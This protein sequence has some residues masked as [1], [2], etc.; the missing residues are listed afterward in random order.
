MRE[1]PAEL[2]ELQRLLDDSH[3]RAGEHLTGII[4]ADRTLRASEICGLMTGMRVLA[5]ATVT[6]HGEPRI[7][8]VDGHFLHGR[9]VFTTSGTAA[10]TRHLRARPATSVAHIDGEDVAVYCHGRAEP[11]TPDHPD[12]AGVEE[13]LVAHYGSSPTSWGPDIAYFRV[14][15]SW[16]V[17]YAWRRSELLARAEVAEEPRP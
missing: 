2:A 6:A 8:G 7:S 11:L 9:W 13:H 10:K 16:M 4:S 12:F 1:T 14:Q 15:P 5:V 17:G 3:A